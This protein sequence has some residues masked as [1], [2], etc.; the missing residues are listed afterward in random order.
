VQAAIYL[1]ALHRQLRARLGA[2]YNPGQQLGG[3]IYWFIRGLD[4]PARGEYA[5]AAHPP[6]LKLLDALD[7]LLGSSALAS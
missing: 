5:V 3:A 6:V 4:G 7:Q 1:L 2:A